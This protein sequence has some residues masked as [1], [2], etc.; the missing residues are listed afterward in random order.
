M[1][2]ELLAIPGVLL[3]LGAALLPLIPEKL[4]SS[5]FLIFPVAALAMAAMHQDGYTLTGAIGNYDLILLEVDSLSRVFGLIIAFAAV[6]GGIYAYHLKDL[7]QQCAALLYAAGA[8]GVVYAGDLFTL[9]VYWEL[10]AVSSTWLI[11]ATRTDAARAAGMR[12]LVYHVL[13]G[14]LLFAGIILHVTQTGSL[15]I[16]SFEQVYSIS[17]ILI[18]LGVGVNAAFIPIHTWLSDAYPKSTITG[19]IFLNSFTTKSA[20]Y[21]LI[22]MFPGWDILI[23]IGVIMAIYGVMYAVICKDIREILTY[24]IISQLGFMIAAIGVGT[25]LALNGAAA[26]AV[27]NILNKSLLFMACGAVL[28]ATGTSKM[29]HLGGLVKKLPYVLGLYLVASLSISGLPLFTA[30]VTKP[31]AVTAIGYSG[32]D[33]AM[34]LLIF[35]SIGTFLSVGLKLPYYT[36]FHADSYDKE[37]KP[38]PFNMYIGMGFVAVVCMV[39]GIAPS[40]LYAFL[41]YE[42]DFNPYTIYLFVEIMQI[43]IMTF[44]GFWMLKHLMKGKLVIALDLDWFYRKASP[45]A[46]RMFIKSTDGFFGWAEKVVL[47][48][49]VLSTKVFRNPMTWLNP[50]GNKEND[51]T[52]YSPGMEVVMSFILVCF[53]AFS[54]FYFL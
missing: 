16:E 49:A 4:R 18:F 39:I 47:N 23:W 12:Y 41:P 48:T 40:T 17:N 38:I 26:L 3:V 37:I 13:G 19:V 51:A 5:V 14:G 54:L 21:V 10:M 50:F 20:V 34:L 35:V 29:Y 46:Y 31:M 30:F 25:E 8:L 44:I 33:T 7:G 6:F 9:I 32:Y 1:T 53:L 15:A 52:T 45:A 42:T 24:H 22:R 11:W 36:W 43:A 2:I 28:Y 27:S